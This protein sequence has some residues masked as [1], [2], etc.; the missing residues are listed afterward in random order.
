[1]VATAPDPKISR[2]L[3]AEASLVQAT[4]TCRT[5]TPVHPEDAS[6]TNLLLVWR[7]IVLDVD[8]L[9]AI[10]KKH[11]TGGLQRSTVS[12]EGKSASPVTWMMSPSYTRVNHVRDKP[13]AG[14][15][16]T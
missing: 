8:A 3:A 15:G 9:P 16:M 5:V 2:G 14:K 1:M 10:V 4:A 13:D 6:H 11:G 12:P 7:R